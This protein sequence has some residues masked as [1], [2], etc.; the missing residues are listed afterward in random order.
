M[1]KLI[2]RLMYYDLINQALL[3]QIMNTKDIELKSAC[4]IRYDQN[5]EKVTEILEKLN[6]KS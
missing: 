2:D 3:G 4:L 5:M 6:G 1:K